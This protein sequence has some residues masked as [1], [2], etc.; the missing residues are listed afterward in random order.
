MDGH[1][2]SSVWV[3]YADS[4][5]LFFISFLAISLILLANFA[6][7]D[8]TAVQE[9]FSE[10]LIKSIGP[11]KLKKWDAEVLTDGTVRFNK[12]EN[13]FDL[14]KAMLKEQFKADLN[15]FIPLYLQVMQMPQ[16]NGKISEIH[17]DGHTSAIW[18][19]ITS[20]KEAYFHNMVLSQSRTVNTLQFVLAHPSVLSQYEWYRKH[21]VANGY[22]SSRP[23]INDPAAPENQRVEFKVIIDDPRDSRQA[24]PTKKRREWE[25][26]IQEKS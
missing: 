23:R 26:N 22:S 10:V 13:Q 6:E 14:G 4:L 7:S 19:S 5:N 12:P 18:N 8:V 3:G 24:P 2:V 21:I 11:E 25:I 15:E 9:K 16:F 20:E 17:I 1:K